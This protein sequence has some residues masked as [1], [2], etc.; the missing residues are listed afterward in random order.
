MR[1]REC[2][3]YLLFISHEKYDW[4][5]NWSQIQIQIDALPFQF[6]GIY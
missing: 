2:V 6:D 5:H 3:A 4:R 1:M